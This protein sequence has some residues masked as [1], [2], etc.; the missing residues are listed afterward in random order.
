MS[1]LERHSLEHPST[2]RR[3]EWLESSLISMASIESGIACIW[4]P[5][6]QCRGAYEPVSEV[7]SPSGHE[8]KR[9][10]NLRTHKLGVEVL[11]VS[12]TLLQGAMFFY[13]ASQ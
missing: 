13:A 5:P 11:H 4:P 6:T 1:V 3:H 9:Q 2:P 8:M 10:A 12:E 7:L